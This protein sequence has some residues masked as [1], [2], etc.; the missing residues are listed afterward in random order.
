MSVVL[1]WII[2]LREWVKTLCI[3]LI[4]QQQTKLPLASLTWKDRKAD[5]DSQIL[6]QWLVFL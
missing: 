2:K 3:L 4:M 1:K 5:K 6:L